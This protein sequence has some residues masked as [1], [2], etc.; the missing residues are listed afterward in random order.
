M[1]K[2]DIVSKY[3]MANSVTEAVNKSKR[4]PV[5]EVYVHNAWFD[6]AANYAF[7]FEPQPPSGFKEEKP[8]PKSRK[9]V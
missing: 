3:V 9:Y 5:H 7:N 6:K 2:Q 4:M 1:N 8:K